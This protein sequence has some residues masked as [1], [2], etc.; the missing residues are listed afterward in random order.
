MRVGSTNGTGAMLRPGDGDGWVFVT[1][2]GFREV[3]IVMRGV[4]EVW[5]ASRAVP[6]QL[7]V[8]VGT[9]VVEVGW[10]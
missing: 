10:E 9:D 7:M 4:A 5:L 1:A 6:Q 2:P 3:P 8:G